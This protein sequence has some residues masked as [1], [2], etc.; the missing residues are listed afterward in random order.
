MAA[1]E[2]ESESVEQN[3]PGYNRKDSDQT[4]GII[5]GFQAFSED[6]KDKSAAVMLQKKVVEA[7][8]RSFVS[9]TRVT[10]GENAL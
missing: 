5:G 8:E 3:S 2:G 1:I 4:L 7:N 6:L 9:Y 10:S